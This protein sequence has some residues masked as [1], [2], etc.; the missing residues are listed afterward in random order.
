[1]PRRNSNARRTVAMRKLRGI[2][3]TPRTPA[4][5]CPSGKVRFPDHQAAARALAN[6]RTKAAAGVDTRDVSPIRSYDC[7]LC[8]GHHLT[9]KAR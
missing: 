7:P 2:A 6:R 9:S 8:S 4:R 5:R 3:R 1:M